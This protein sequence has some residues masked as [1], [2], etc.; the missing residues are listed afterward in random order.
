M[1]KNTIISKINEFL[2]D[3]F[4]VEEQE[5]QP[6]ANLTEALELDSLDFVDLVVAVESNFG[7]KLVA[8]DFANIVTLQDFYDL[9]EVKI[10]AK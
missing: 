8:E 3:E 9:L 7:V 2:I 4:E 5:I 10:N 6:E 1:D